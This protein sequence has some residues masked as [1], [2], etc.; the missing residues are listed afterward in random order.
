MKITLIG[1]GNLATSLGVALYKAGHE[2]L[3]V[4]SRTTTAAD[5]LARS[6]Q[7]PLIATQVTEINTHSDLYIVALTDT[8]LQQL[9]PSLGHHLPTK[10]LVHTAGSL[11]L[12]TLINPRR[13]VF[14]PL[15][16]F[17]KQRV[18][19]FNEIPIF[20]EANNPADLQILHSLAHQLSTIVYTLSSSERTIL[21]LAAVFS[22]N[23]TNHCYTLAARLLQQHSLPFNILLPLIRETV[24]KLEHLTPEQAQTGPARRHDHAVIQQHLNMLD[25][26][27]DSPIKNVY[28]LMTESIEISSNPYNNYHD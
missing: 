19:P 6:L 15:Q 18:L 4:F 10:L 25:K 23:F 9:A 11:P 21:H 24:A 17:S 3:Q 22:C 7:A 20:I 27:G 12:D 5:T 13:G 14:Y 2:I 16:T 26:Y 8:A 1:S 28:R